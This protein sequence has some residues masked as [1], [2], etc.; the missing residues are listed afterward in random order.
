MIRS[1][2]FPVFF[3][4]LSVSSTA[5]WKFEYA[6]VDKLSSQ[7][8]D[9]NSSYQLQMYATSL[10]IN[11]QY[12]LATY[13]WDKQQPPVK[14]NVDSLFRVYKSAVELPA[15]A[16]LSRLSAPYDILLMDELHH[17]PQHRVFL[18]SMLKQ[19]YVNGYRYLALEALY[20]DVMKT[21]TVS[22]DA[23]V[24]T[25]EP[26]FANMIKE[27]IRLGFTVFGYEGSD[28]SSNTIRD[29]I[30]AVN[31]LKQWDPGNGKLIVYGG[32]AHINKEETRWGKSVGYWLTRAGYK[33]FSATQTGL[34]YSDQP[35]YVHPFY[36]FNKNKYP[37]ILGI[38]DQQ[39]FTSRKETDLMIIHPVTKIENGLPG[40]LFN[41][42]PTQPQ[43]SL[44]AIFTPQVASYCKI[45]VAKEYGEFAVPYG[46]YS[47]R[48][49]MQQNLWLPDGDYVLE[50]EQYP[51]R[52]EV[53]PF[54]VK[55]GAIVQ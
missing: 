34:Y 54:S 36:T 3:C 27:A 4:V 33:T 52:K 40:W 25:R 38:S 7:L 42:Y 17:L 26:N 5:Q 28:F 35:E 51:L 2:F 9:P 30:A 32:P 12:L 53:I 44:N 19:L 29:S 11:Q 24:Y 15:Q 31:I 10:S 41:L 6:P 14:Y 47:F 21:K 18:H 13:Y 20:E 23:G 55:S 45:Y 48:Q 22:V 1:F 39:Y 49:G 50:V 37:V 43:V 8:T 16:T 46:I